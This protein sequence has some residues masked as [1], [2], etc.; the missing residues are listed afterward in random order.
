MKNTKSIG[1]G[2]LLVLS[3]ILLP[4]FTQGQTSSPPKDQSSLADYAR[5]VRKDTGDTKGKPK[6]FDN[7]NLPKNDKLSIV[8]QHPTAEA[9]SA[10]AAE[11]GEK[12]VPAD[13]K[14][15]GEKPATV[16]AKAAVPSD[17][18]KA[19]QQAEWK[20][21]EDKLAA[22]KDQINLASRELDVTQRE[23]QLRAA[24]MYADAGNRLRNSAQ[25]DKEEAS[26]KQQ[27]AD[28]QKALDDAKQKLEDLKEEAHKAGV[29][30]S[31]TG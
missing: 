13:G 7:D 3:A 22:Q 31:I 5:K 21:W 23:Y 15:T 29:P 18:E 20:A 1:L 9:D 14:A 4:S 10:P 24:A 28:K 11:T 27:I 16:Q 17:D 30:S 25:W 19:K 8:G 26:Y 2:L 12:A 6:V